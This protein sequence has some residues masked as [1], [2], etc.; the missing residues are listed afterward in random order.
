[1]PGA[2]IVIIADV[3]D[4][5]AGQR[6]LVEEFESLLLAL[7]VHAITRPGWDRFKSILAMATIEAGNAEAG[8]QGYE[9]ALAQWKVSRWYDGDD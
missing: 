2:V 4:P 3:P 9:K 1:M 8:Q 7:D 5:L 6:E